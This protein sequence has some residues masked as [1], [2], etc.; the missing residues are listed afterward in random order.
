[1]CVCVRHVGKRTATACMDAPVEMPAAKKKKL[2]EDAQDDAAA[3]AT[4]EKSEITPL[5]ERRKKKKRSSVGS[6]VGSQ[7]RLMCEYAVF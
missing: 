6:S 2:N 1:M 7:V 4:P 3:A 5:G